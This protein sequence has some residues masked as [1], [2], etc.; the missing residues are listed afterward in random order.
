MGVAILYIEH[1]MGFLYYVKTNASLQLTRPPSSPNL[2]LS[3]AI[4]YAP[5]FFYKFLGSL[6]ESCGPDACHVVL[7]VSE[8]ELNQTDI[9]ELIEHFDAH[10]ELMAYDTYVDEW[11]RL[12][13]DSGPLSPFFARTNMAGYRFGYL[14]A[15]LTRFL[16]QPQNEASFPYIFVADFRDVLFQDNVFERIPNALATWTPSHSNRSWLFGSG[17]REWTTSQAPDF[18]RD[19]VTDPLHIPFLFAFSETQNFI[20]GVSGHNADWVLGAYG[21]AVLLSLFFRNVICAGTV[22]GN[23]QGILIWL[24]AMVHEIERL[25]ARKEPYDSFDQAIHLVLLHQDKMKELGLRT[26]LVKNENNGLVYTMATMVQASRT[27]LGTVETAPGVAPAVLHQYDRFPQ[28]KDFYDHKYALVS[29]EEQHID[30]RTPPP[31]PLTLFPWAVEKP[32]GR[33]RQFYSMHKKPIR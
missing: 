10:T 2:I 27:V 32:V 19:A 23:R 8:K 9:V 29:K 4:G 15:W 31:P 12:L 14:L 17:G 11:P 13:N 5:L 6:R 21:H 18:L 20:L 33:R 3:V 22:L 28:L 1:M 7:F 26:F 16:K 24:K 30:K 25:S